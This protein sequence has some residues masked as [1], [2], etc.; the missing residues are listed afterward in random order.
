V[1]IVE[2]GGSGGGIAAP[3]AKPVLQY[4]LDQD[5][6]AVQAGQEAD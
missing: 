1:I 6:T 2:R 5:V 3:T 4:L